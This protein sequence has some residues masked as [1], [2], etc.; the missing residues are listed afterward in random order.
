MS[1]CHLKRCLPQNCTTGEK[2]NAL[3]GRCEKI[4]CQPGFNI[5]TFGKCV[6]KKNTY[7]R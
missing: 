6:G 1:V 5:T 2:F 4:N 7:A 3:V